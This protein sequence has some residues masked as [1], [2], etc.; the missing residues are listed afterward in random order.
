MSQNFGGAVHVASK[1]RPQRISGGR[2][3]VR[4]SA[5]QRR[6]KRCL[7]GRQ[8]QTIAAP[9]KNFAHTARTNTKAITRS[10][11]F[12]LCSVTWIANQKNPRKVVRFASRIPRHAC[13]VG[14]NTSLLCL[15]KKAL[16]PKNVALSSEKRRIGLSRASSAVQSSGTTHPR[17]GCIVL[18]SAI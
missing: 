10:G 16:A 7:R 2:R 11:S 1:R 12:V 4:G 3:I 6:T 13:T 8:T 15:R 5:W 17:I 9:P 14:R 18:T